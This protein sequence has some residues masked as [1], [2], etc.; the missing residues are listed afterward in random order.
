M[1]R[2]FGAPKGAPIKKGLFG[3]LSAFPERLLMKRVA[4]FADAGYFWVQVCSLVLGTRGNRA[5]VRLNHAALRAEMLRE[6]ANQ[7]PTADLLRVYWYDGPG[8]QGK[9]ADHKAIEALDDFKLRLGTRNGVGQQKAVDGL[10]IADMISLTQSRAITDALL[11]TGDA[12]M[13]PG[14]VAA[15]AM[16]LRVHLLTIG[17]GAA[18]SPYLAA[19]AD[20]KTGWDLGRVSTFA[21]QS[22]QPVPAA[23]V[24]LVA[25]VV[26]P[27]PAPAPAQNPAPVQAAPAP[28]A[29]A[30][31]AAPVAAP[32]PLNFVAIA[33]AAHAALIAGPHAANIAALTPQVFQLPQDIDKALLGAGRKQAGRMLDEQEKRTL[34]VEFK[35]L[36]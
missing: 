2:Y 27:A 34:R 9:S 12:D 32:V 8:P 17:S 16:G 4:V 13:T 30:P 5:N 28:I 31:A 11:I 7:F 14:V 23:Q 20:V 26:P 10:I 25:P 35:K 19:E 15:Q 36:L 29:A 33:S 1:P 6:V 21:V 18:T 22:P 3:A 24:P